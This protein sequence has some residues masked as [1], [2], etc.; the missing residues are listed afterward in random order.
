METEAHFNQHTAQN[1]KIVTYTKHLTLHKIRQML[2]THN[3]TG[4]TT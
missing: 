4:Q 2:R 3:N 1:V